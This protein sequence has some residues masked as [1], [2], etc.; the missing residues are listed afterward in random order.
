MTHFPPD[1]TPDKAAAGSQ[2]STS[3]LPMGTDIEALQQEIQ[4]IKAQQTET[5]SQTRKNHLRLIRQEHRFLAVWRNFYYYRL[6]G[7]AKERNAALW[8]VLSLFVP[9]RFTVVAL[10]IAGGG[11]FTLLLMQTNNELLADQNY[12]LRRQIY[13]Q[14]QPDRAAQLTGIKD[15]LYRETQN[16]I[17]ARSKWSAL[18]QEE[19]SGLEEPDRQSFFNGRTREEALKQFFQ[20]SANPLD[21]PLQITPRRLIDIVKA[22]PC[23]QF[24]IY[25]SDKQRIAD[26]NGGG[27]KV[28]TVSDRLPANLR[29]AL[30]ADIIW[31][32]SR[33]LLP[34]LDLLLVAANLQGSYLESMDLQGADLKKANLRSANLFNSN[35]QGADLM[36][37]DLRGAKLMLVNLQGAKL[38]YTNLENSNLSRADLRDAELKGASLIGADLREAKLRG[39]DLRK[40]NFLNA[41][42]N[43]EQLMSAMYW[44][45]AKNIKQ[46]PPTSKTLPKDEP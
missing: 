40:A 33:I 44:R 26:L 6:E 12:E 14:A 10:T 41:F 1:R 17:D 18:S 31:E 29:G 23:E 32:E 8:A 27:D 19:A 4:T 15:K 13:E 34:M 16:S 2:R 45:A 37:A 42:Y 28:E 46:C 11:V 36:G 21:E 3:L 30:L 38:P 20:L 5:E 9:G 24:G 39:A 25:C 22:A 7:D 35:L 43:C